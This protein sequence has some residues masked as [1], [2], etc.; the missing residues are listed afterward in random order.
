M[1]DIVRKKGDKIDLPALSRAFG[2]K[3]VE[4]SAL[5]S[6]GILEAANLAIDAARNGKIVPSHIFSGEVEHTLAHIEEAAVHNLPA[7]VQRW[8]AIKIFERDTKVIERLGISADVIAHI[9]SDIKETENIFDDDAESIITNERYEYITRM[10]NGI[11]KKKNPDGLTVSDKIDRVVTNRFAALPIFALIMFLV[12][13]ISITTVGTWAT[14]WTNDALFGDG[15]HLFGIGNEE[16]EEELENYVE[17]NGVFQ[18][19]EG[20]IAYA[21]AYDL[22]VKGLEELK[23]AVESGDIVAL[24]EAVISY[25]S[26]ITIP[27]LYDSET[28][29]E[30]TLDIYFEEI[31]LGIV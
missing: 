25:G 13:F 17:E 9:E 7:E 18:L 12:Y 19:V 3:M 22:D 2:C 6:D 21:E 10:L 8:Y 26:Q 23:L 30:I 20:N 4:I 15:F 29:E 24:E 11:Y 28:Y 1:M 31:F 5:K 14:D 16:Y 27:G